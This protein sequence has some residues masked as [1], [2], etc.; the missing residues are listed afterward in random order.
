MQFDPV[1]EDDARPLPFAQTRH[2]A[3]AQITHALL[4]RYRIATP[5]PVP[6]LFAMVSGI[7]GIV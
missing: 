2:G 4:K 5:A 3:S 7:I 1:L 6:C